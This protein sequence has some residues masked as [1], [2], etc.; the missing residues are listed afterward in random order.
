[1]I[2]FHTYTSFCFLLAHIDIEDKKERKIR[3]FNEVLIV[4][5]IEEYR[6][7]GN[8][9]LAFSSLIIHV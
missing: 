1:M 3:I 6:L 9:Q 4:I 2:I 8:Y 5:R 7:V